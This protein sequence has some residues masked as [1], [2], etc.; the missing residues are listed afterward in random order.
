MVNAT[1]VPV[2]QSSEKALSFATDSLKFTV[3]V[4]LTATPVSP[5]DGVV[6]VTDGG[7]STFTVKDAVP[8]R[9][10]RRRPG[11]SEP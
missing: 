2:G 1:G 7:S 9:S 10:S 6:D 5:F 3:I 8:V 4:L 11:Q